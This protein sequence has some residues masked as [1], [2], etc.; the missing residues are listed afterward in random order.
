MARGSRNLHSRAQSSGP[1]CVIVDRH[2]PDQ[3]L[4]YGVFPLLDIA[5]ACL[6]K[7]RFLRRLQWD[8]HEVQR[9]QDGKLRSL[10][11]HSYSTVPYYQQKYNANGISPSSVRKCEDLAMLPIAT[12]EDLKHD[13]P[14]RTVSSAVPRRRTR[15]CHTSGS[16][17]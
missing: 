13:F 5:T 1:E 14:R 6:R 17:G 3:I 8:H 9:W 2:M 16:T 12:K 11:W 4:R 7:Y 10:I 15:L